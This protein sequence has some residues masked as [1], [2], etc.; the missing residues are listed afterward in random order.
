MSEKNVVVK[1][2]PVEGKD[3]SLDHEYRVYTKLGGGAGIPHV[4]GF[5]IEDGFNVMVVEHLGPSLEDLSF[6]VHAQN[7]LTP[8]CAARELSDHTTYQ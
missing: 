4:H 6:S 2:E 7:C 3:H 5:V 1:L 8:S